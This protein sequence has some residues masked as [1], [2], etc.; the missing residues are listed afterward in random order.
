[1]TVEFPSR[2]T[3]YRLGEVADVNWGDTSVTKASYVTQG[4]PAYSAV[5]PDGFLP[6]YDFE[7]T[8]VVVSA[9]GVNCGKIWLARGRWS[10]IKNTIRFWSTHPGVDTEFL[11][12]LTSDPDMWPKRGTA[13]P[14]ISQGDAR[15]L[16]I[17][18]PSLDEQRAIAGV[19]GALDDKIELN[20]QMSQTL[21][22][23]A[24]A[25]FKSWFVDFDPIVAK[26]TGRRP[27]GTDEKTGAV[28][29][30]RF[31]ESDFGPIPED[32]RLSTIGREVR[33]VGG[34]TPRTNEP[35]F[36]EGGTIHWITPRDLSKLTD[37]IVLETDRR[38]TEEGLARISSGLLPP[39]TVLL[40]SR[41]PIGYL[42]IAEVPV[43]VNQ[44]F[45]AMACDGA[46]PTHYVFHWTR[47]N[48]DE[49]LTRAGGT[50]FAEISKANFRPIP[51]LVPSGPVLTAFEAIVS[52]IYARLVANVKESRTLSE[53]RDILLPKLLSGEIRV[54]QTEKIV[55]GAI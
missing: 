17:A 31:V 10:C 16:R 1:M 9:I 42:A 5:G 8:G 13:Q 19:L 37:P 11:Y 3:R 49:I 40:S 20:R 7:R 6:Y 24:Q 54:R 4:F 47:E 26:A 34:S 18:V 35:R 44:G 45:I 52:P 28:F 53:L 27:F 48:I 41:A 33:V 22:A 21:E 36:W 25:I 29:P 43:A 39:G 51:V 23:M 32:W 55:G 30:H 46:L 14:F 50:T 15:D 12:S 2:W 38:I